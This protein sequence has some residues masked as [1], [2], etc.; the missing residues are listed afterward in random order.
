MHAKIQMPFSVLS[1]TAL[2]IFYTVERSLYAQ[3]I[4]SLS[5]ATVFFPGNCPRVNNQL[6]PG[7][8][9]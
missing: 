3:V 4:T 1:G 9:Q 6:V 7:A 2:L 5:S 8:K